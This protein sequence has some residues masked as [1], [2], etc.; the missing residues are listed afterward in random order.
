MSDL[1]GVNLQGPSG[2]G[3]GG[4]QVQVGL[5]IFSRQIKNVHASKEIFW[6]KV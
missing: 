4:K 3:G 5:R 1:P 2:T 6:K